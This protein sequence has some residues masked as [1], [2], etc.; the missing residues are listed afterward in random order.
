[1]DDTLNMDPSE[2]ESALPEQG[3]GA[4]KPLNALD[5]SFAGRRDHILT[6]FGLAKVDPSQRVLPSYQSLSPCISV[7]VRAKHAGGQI[8]Q[9][10]TGLGEIAEELQ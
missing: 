2:P 9:I 6:R 4:H 5:W 1:M 10:F 3:L 7:P 8:P